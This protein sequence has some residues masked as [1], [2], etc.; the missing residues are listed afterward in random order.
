VKVIFAVPKNL[1][2]PSYSKASLQMA[3]ISNR[4]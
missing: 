4:K 1:F 2:I 3:K